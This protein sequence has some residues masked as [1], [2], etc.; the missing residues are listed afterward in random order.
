MCED[1]TAHHFP[2]SEI[3]TAVAGQAPHNVLRFNFDRDNDEPHSHFTNVQAI[4][5]KM[6][7]EL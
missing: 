1:H 5:F 3:H 7:L 2:D 4:Q 6:T